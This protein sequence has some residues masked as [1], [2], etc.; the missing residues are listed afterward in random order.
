[1]LLDRGAGIDCG[2]DD[3]EFVARGD[4]LEAAALQRA[5]LHHFL[6]VAIEHT[7][8]DEF[9]IGAGDV[10]VAGSVHVNA[11]GGG[12]CQRAMA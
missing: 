10:E 4:D 5:H 11:G 2:A 1:M 3:A 12:S 8:V 6:H 7:D 9:R